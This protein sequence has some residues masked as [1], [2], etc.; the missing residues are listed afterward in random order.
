MCCAL[1]PALCCFNLASPPQATTKPATA[2]DSAHCAAA[3]AAEL[4]QVETALINDRQHHVAE[5]T[6][7]LG[8]DVGVDGCHFAKDVLTQVR[9]NL[10]AAARR[11]ADAIQAEMSRQLAQRLQQ[12]EVRGGQRN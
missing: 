3:V 9:P 11:D 10:H 1:L 5:D 4:R 8:D 6:I 2:G 7:P 12:A